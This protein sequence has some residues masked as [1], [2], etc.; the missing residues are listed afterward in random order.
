MGGTPAKSQRK[1]PMRLQIV[2]ATALALLAGSASATAIIAGSDWHYDQV[3]AS[4]AASVS[5]PWTFTVASGTAT[6]SIV[7][8]FVAG[9]LYQLFSS[10]G[11]LATSSYYAGAASASANPFFFQTHY[12]D[13]AYSKIDYVVG[14]GSYSFNIYGDGA[15]G[16]PAGFGVRLTASPVVPTVPDAASWAL[17][18]VGFGMIGGTLRRRATTV[19]SV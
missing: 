1:K 16:Y 11:L 15:G 13:A 7:D 6:F 9:D 8:G 3:T 10:N 19:V 4:N 14:P 18:V 5:S 12:E 2:T 17:M